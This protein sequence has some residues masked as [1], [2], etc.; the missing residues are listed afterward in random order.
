M[1]SKLLCS[2]HTSIGQVSYTHI[3][4]WKLLIPANQTFPTKLNLKYTMG[5]AT[6]KIKSID[7]NY[8]SYLHASF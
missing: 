1:N 7:S 8:L 2:I 6:T 3:I 5:L 4:L